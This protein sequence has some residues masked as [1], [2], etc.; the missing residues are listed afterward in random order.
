MA[1]YKEGAA[2]QTRTWVGPLAKQL[3]II[4]E[5]D[6]DEEA[7]S[8]ID[9]KSE[10]AAG[11]IYESEEEGEMR[12]EKGKKE[13]EELMRKE[14]KKELDAT[15]IIY[16]SEEER[17]MRFEKGRKELEEWMRKEEKKEHYKH[18]IY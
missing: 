12:F 9:E 4:P 14:K 7:S 10:D 3:V 16:E 5:K 8:E 1:G 6:V 2:N 11:T 17:E 13:L 15:E 18:M